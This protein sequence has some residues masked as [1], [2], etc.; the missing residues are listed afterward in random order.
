MEEKISWEPLG[1]LGNISAWN[2]PYFVSTNV[3]IPG[4]L[5]GNSV[6]YKPSEYASLTGMELVKLLHE[7]GVPEDVLIP[8]IG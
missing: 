4:L 1:V 5:T 8:V 7:A 6:V 2:Y 3:I